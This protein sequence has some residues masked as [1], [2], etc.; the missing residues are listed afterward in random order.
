MSG[1]SVSPGTGQ[2]CGGC[3]CHINAPESRSQVKPGVYWHLMCLYRRN[4]I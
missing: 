2:I 3:G 1:E 4:R